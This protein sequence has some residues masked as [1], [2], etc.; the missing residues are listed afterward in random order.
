L[1]EPDAVPGCAMIP[2]LRAYRG[3]WVGGL[4]ARLSHVPT[5]RHRSSVGIGSPIR[6]DATCD[7]SSSG[8]LAIPRIEDGTRPGAE[9][10]VRNPIDTNDPPSLMARASRRFVRRAPCAISIAIQRVVLPG[11]AP[12][13]RPTSAARCSC[14]S[15]A[16]HRDEGSEDVC[17]GQVVRATRCLQGR[18]SP[19]LGR[20]EPGT[21]GS[22]SRP[23]RAF[24]PRRASHAVDAAR[25][26]STRTDAQL[27][28]RLARVLDQRRPESPANCGVRCRTW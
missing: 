4:L 2:S 13:P 27:L 21:T 25:S 23:M 5:S 28:P 22:H 6:N 11:V 8:D 7:P 24:A 26:V 9:T 1:V 14:W 18:R 17:D 15:A 16:P 3:F 12:R 10:S 20:Q 19:E